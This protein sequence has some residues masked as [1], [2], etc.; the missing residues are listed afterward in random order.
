MEPMP[1]IDAAIGLLICPVCSAGLVREDRRLCCPQGHSFDIARQG[2]VNLLN[3]PAPTNADTAAM[4]AARERFLDAGFYRPILDALI[5]TCAGTERIAEAGAGP[6]YYLSGVVEACAPRQHLALDI[7]VAAARRA[8]KRGLASAVAN[9]WAGLPVRTGSL[10]RLLCIFAPRNPEDFARVLAPG[11]ELIVV[12]PTEDH[13]AELREQLGLL[14]VPADKTSQLDEQLGAV[15]LVPAERV[16]VTFTLEADIPA[17]T[18]L[19]AMGPNA[20][21]RP[22]VPDRRLPVQVCV[23]LSRYRQATAGPETTELIR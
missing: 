9:S 20:F 19:V 2:Y 16:D 1:A 18:D 7:S 12:T 8:A 22:P 11:G 14:D 4:V 5:P 10:D 17:I 13:L 23:T 6:G 3:G 21:H 15:G